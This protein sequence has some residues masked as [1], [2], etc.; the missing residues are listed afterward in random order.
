MG[1]YCS[2]S[3]N[4]IECRPATFHVSSSSLLKVVLG[5]S[6]KN[7]VHEQK[8]L[9]NRLATVHVSCDILMYYF[10]KMSLYI[11]YQ[12]IDVTWQCFYTVECR[13]DFTRRIDRIDCET[14]VFTIV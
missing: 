5:D 2:G 13:N 9:T 7:S 10:M 12:P 11:H 8:W 6:L 3:N 1:V 14:T 4:P